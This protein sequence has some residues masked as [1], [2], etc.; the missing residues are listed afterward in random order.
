M[1]GRLLGI[2]LN[3]H[4]AGARGGLELAR[5]SMRSNEGTPLGDD[6][7]RIARE[8]EEDLLTLEE[9]MELA[10]VQRARVKEGAAWIA[11]RLARLKLNGRLLAY[12]PLSR[13]EELE[14]LRLGIEGKRSLWKNLAEVRGT[15]GAWQGV[16]FEALIA[17]AESQI[18]ILESHRVATVREAFLEAS[19]AS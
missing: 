9:L 16:D 1:E 4:R 19:P 8:V 10:G 13:V 2:Y 11:E 12:S 18:A 7:M 6:L 14:F 3:D 17:R 5:R 15:V